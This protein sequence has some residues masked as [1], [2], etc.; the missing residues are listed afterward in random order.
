[1]RAL[2]V[3]DDVVSR[4]ALTD[5][6][7]SFIELKVV[8]AVDGQDAWEKMEMGPAPMICCCDVQMPRLSGI[9]LLKRVRSSPRFKDIPFVLVTAA[10]DLDTVRKAVTLGISHYIVKPFHAREARG[11]LQK[12]LNAAWER[13]A[14]PPPATL[15][16]LNIAPDQLMTYLYSLRG[17]CAVFARDLR[18][19]KNLQDVQDVVGRLKGLHTGCLTLGLH[20]AA[21]LV[22]QIPDERSDIEDER[23]DIERVEQ[24]LI[25]IELAISSQEERVKARHSLATSTAMRR[26]A[27]A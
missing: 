17:Q 4:M 25:E 5:L 24:A 12:I 26:T 10:S 8:E 18:R 23:S 16:R 14:E 11:S 19:S 21:G 2:V 27:L 20:Y 7:R 6:M 13:I 3:D 15:N 1:M 9:D 22:I